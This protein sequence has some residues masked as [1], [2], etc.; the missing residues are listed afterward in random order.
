MMYLRVKRKRSTIFLH[1]EPS[2]TFKV[3]KVKC[4]DV[5]GVSPSLV[6]LFNTEKVEYNELSTIADLEIKND[7]V[8]YLVLKKDGGGDSYEPFEVEKFSPPG[9]DAKA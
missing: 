3:L 8:L 1:V 2:D 6:G 5:F 4:G 9:E 7:A